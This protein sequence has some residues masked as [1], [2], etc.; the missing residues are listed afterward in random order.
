MGISKNLF[1]R[2]I[3]VVSSML[4]SRTYHFVRL[5]FLASLFLATHPDKRVFR[6]ALMKAPDFWKTNNWKATAMSPLSALFKLGTKIRE[7]NATPKNAGKPV[8]CVGN[9]VAGGTGKTP[10]SLALADIF[11]A[12]K[13]TVHFLCKGYKGKI[14]EPTRV[15]V[16]KHTAADVGDEALLLSDKCP[17]WVAK[18]RAA[19]AEAAAKGADIVIMD[20]GLQ[21]PHIEK[22]FNIIVVDG[23]YGFGNTKVIPA[24]PMRETVENGL[25]KADLVILLGNDAYNVEML[26]RLCSS[27]PIIRATLA[28]APLDK[29]LQK[30]QMVAFAGIG[31][32]EKFFNNLKAEGC[33]VIMEMPFP[34]H[35]AF[36]ETDVTKLTR[37][38][39][40][41]EC[42]LVTTTKDYVRLTGDFKQKVTPLPVAIAW[43]SVTELRALLRTKDLL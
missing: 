29:I 19:G 23:E 20:D 1:S 30:Q 4:G 18:D 9:L 27:V 42:K 36:T 32:P 14:T 6:S 2:A 12:Q 25:K 21:N 37:I 28:L 38:A 17:T 43:S 10:V 13:K 41:K 24:G 16:T 33:N 31:R 8:I 34:D 40:L 11:L 35:H 7:S 22:A 5:R 26:I 15:D 39:K 3:G